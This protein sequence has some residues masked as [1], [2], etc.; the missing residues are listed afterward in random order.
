[1]L[2]ELSS[3][4]ASAGD[5]RAVARL[6]SSVETMVT[7]YSAVWPQLLPDWMQLQSEQIALARAL[8]EHALILKQQMEQ[9]SYTL[10]HPQHGAKHR[11]AAAYQA[12]QQIHVKL[13]HVTRA[14]R[15]S[16]ANSSNP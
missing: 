12:E 2:N 13:Q 5:A 15:R 9:S 4:A 10:T 1:M 3:A 11:L 14:E 8:H 7:S 16:D 6:R